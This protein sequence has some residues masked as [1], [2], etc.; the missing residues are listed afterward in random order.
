MFS[1][2]SLLAHLM[3]P[4]AMDVSL[5]VANTH[6]NAMEMPQLALQLSENSSILL[7]NAA[8]QI[9]RNAEELLHTILITE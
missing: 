3:D 4:I 1:H 8:K 9:N 2:T 5:T 6:I 7:T